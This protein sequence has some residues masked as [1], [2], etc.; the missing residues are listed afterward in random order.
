MKLSNIQSGINV[1]ENSRIIMNTIAIIK[2]TMKDNFKNR[3]V[4]CLR[5]ILE[6][7]KNLLKICFIGIML[8]LVFLVSPVLS[9]WIL[10]LTMPG[11]GF[12]A[13]VGG[14]FIC[15]G[16]SII[17]GIIGTTFRNAFYRAIKEWGVKTNEE[18][19]PTPSLKEITFVF[20][21]VFLFVIAG[22]LLMILEILMK[23]RSMIN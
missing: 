19:S 7:V 1:F 21:I 16:L 14:L 17:V 2:R 4:K 9:F 10:H 6:L 15:I 13:Y 18:T 20:S 23:S 12:L 8:L 5:S 22:A 11:F 3:I